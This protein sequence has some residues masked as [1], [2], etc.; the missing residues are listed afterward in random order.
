MLLDH[1]DSEETLECKALRLIKGKTGQQ[2]PEGMQGPKGAPGP[3]GPKGDTG[4]QGPKGMTVIGPKGSKGA[5][6]DTGLRGPKGA[7]GS[8][9]H[10][11]MKGGRVIGSKITKVLLEVV[12][13]LASQNFVHVMVAGRIIS[14][15]IFVNCG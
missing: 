11:G 1:K 5:R 8:Q 13:L 15:I 6:G 14:R 9:G 12:D 2:G 10:K 3:P 7:T 4:L